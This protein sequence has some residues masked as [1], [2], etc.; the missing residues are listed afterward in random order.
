MDT[1]RSHRSRLVATALA[2]PVGA[3]ALGLTLALAL[4]PAGFAAGGATAPSPRLV[5]PA[6]FALVVAQKG[7]VTIDVRGPGEAFIRG[8]NLSIAFDTLVATRAKLP[9]KTTRLAVYCHSGRRSAIA[10]KT[11]VALGYRDIVELRGGVTAW[12][13]AGRVLAPAPS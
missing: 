12:A 6:Q 11:L 7:T 10:V 1:A 13:A 3:L 9:A 2:A 4:A 5:S 8:T